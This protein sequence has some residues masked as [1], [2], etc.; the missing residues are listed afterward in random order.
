MGGG[1]G[2][3]SRGD[4]L[5][6]FLIGVGWVW[7]WESDGCSYRDGFEAGEGIG[8]RTLSFGSRIQ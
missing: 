3:V 7:G 1:I 5:L 2:F 4:E 8:E 6:I